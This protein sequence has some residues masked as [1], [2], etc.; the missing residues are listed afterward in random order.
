MVKGIQGYNAKIWWG[1]EPKS[2]SNKIVYIK[3]KD[4]DQLISGSKKFQRKNRGNMDWDCRACEGK[5]GY[6]TC[7]NGSHFGNHPSVTRCFA[8]KEGMNF[9]FNGLKF[10]IDCKNGIGWNEKCAYH[11]NFKDKWEKRE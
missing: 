2:E 7:Y 5:Q 11:C 9:I 6:P 10:C 8:I 3:Q 1:N 4:L